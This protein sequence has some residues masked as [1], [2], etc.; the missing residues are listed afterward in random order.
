[1][2]S[3]SDVVGGERRRKMPYLASSGLRVLSEKDVHF[4]Q[5]GELFLISLWHGTQCDYIVEL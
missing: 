3:N 5:A 4:P 2:R 1:M